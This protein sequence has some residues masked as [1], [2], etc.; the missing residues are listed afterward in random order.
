MSVGGS[1]Q[2]VSIGG[3]VF[4]ATADA[5][6]ARRLGGFQSETQMNGDATSR[7]IMT[8]VSWSLSG[9]VLSI[10]ENRADQDFLQDCAD[11]V[12]AGDDGYFDVTITYASNH[13]RQ[14]RGKPTGEIVANSMNSTVSLSLTGPGKLDLQ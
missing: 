2:E 11:G 13:T 8:R 6:A 7:E 5:D 10:D 4:S 3:R 9:V 14:G 12:N 1:I